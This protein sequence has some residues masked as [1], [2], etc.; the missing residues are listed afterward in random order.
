MS[1][2]RRIALLGMLVGVSLVLFL[3]EALLPQPLPF[4]KIGLANTVT[5]FVL[6]TM[7]VREAVAVT[8]LRVA[9]AS[10]FAG[11]LLGPAFALSMAGGLSAALG[12]G[13]AARF[14]APPLGIVGVS[15]VGAVCHNL[16]QLGVVDALY[17]G[18]GAAWGLLPAALLISA[19]AGLATGLAAR[20]ALVKFGRHVEVLRGA[21]A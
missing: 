13:A 18:S 14:G 1:R 2:A 9:A 20:F 6:L 21:T 15:V 3:V 17:A 19:G 4:L 10:L 8:V 16:A 11:T 12:M 5:L 7:G